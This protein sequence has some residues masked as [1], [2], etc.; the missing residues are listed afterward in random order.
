MPTLK[1]VGGVGSIMRLAVFAVA[2]TFLLWGTPAF[3][4]DFDS[5]GVEDQIDNCSEDVNT[6]QVDT[7]TDDCGNLCDADYD[8]SGIVGFPDIFLFWAN[9]HS[10]NPL[11][12]HVLPIPGCIIGFPDFMFLMGS[13][14]DPPGPSG[15][16][17]CP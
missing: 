9:P 5:D 7:D 14:S 13:F 16:T 11:F 2:I 10:G 17:A 1:T 15:T 8:Q 3:A 12:C 4:L 6:G